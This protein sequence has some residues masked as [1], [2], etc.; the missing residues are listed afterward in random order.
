MLRAFIYFKTD[1]KHILHKTALPTRPWIT[2]GWS[3]N[4]SDKYR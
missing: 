4:I 3:W 2:C 1:K